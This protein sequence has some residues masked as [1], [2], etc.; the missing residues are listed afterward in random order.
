MEVYQIRIVKNGQEVAAQACKQAS[1]F[2]AVRHANSMAENSVHGPDH[3]PD[4]IEVW[5]GAPC[6]FTGSPAERDN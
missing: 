5:R 4:H 1:D 2:A 3:L 6:V